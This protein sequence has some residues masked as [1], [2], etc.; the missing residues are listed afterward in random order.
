MS[1]HNKKVQFL[2]SWFGC[3]GEEKKFELAGIEP[4]FSSP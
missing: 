4:W 3:R 1:N 2:K